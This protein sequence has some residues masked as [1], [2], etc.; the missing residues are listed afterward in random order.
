MADPKNCLHCKGLVTISDNMQPVSSKDKTLVYA[1]IKIQCDDCGSNSI[2]HHGI[3]QEQASPSDSL[4]REQILE[5]AVTSW[6][7]SWPKVVRL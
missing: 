5:E 7:K 1:G 3:N 2:T 4:S 6:N